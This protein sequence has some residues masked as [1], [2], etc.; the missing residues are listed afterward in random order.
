MRTAGQSLGR[1]KGRESSKKVEHR[2]KEGHEVERAE[3]RGRAGQEEGATSR[4][5]C[6]VMMTKK[7]T[8]VSCAIII[9]GSKQTKETRD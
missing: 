8:N 5:P 2:C 1:G 6:P 4:T 9:T 3:R 7:T